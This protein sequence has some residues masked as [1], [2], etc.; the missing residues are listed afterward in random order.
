[1]STNDRFGYWLWRQSP[2]T[3]ISA[4]VHSHFVGFFSVFVFSC[5][6]VVPH[7][8]ISYFQ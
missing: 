8:D 3:C 4:A 5:F 6:E 1:V 2:V 7:E